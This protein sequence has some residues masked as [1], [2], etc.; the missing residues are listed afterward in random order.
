MWYLRKMERISFRAHKT[1]EF[2]LSK[3]Q[4]SRMILRDIEIRQ[5]KLFG[6]V[7]RKSELEENILFGYINGKR[8]G[9]R[10]RKTSGWYLGKIRKKSSRVHKNRKET[11]RMETFMESLCLWPDTALKEEGSAT[12]DVSE[13]IWKRREPISGLRCESK[14]QS[15]FDLLEPKNQFKNPAVWNFKIWHRI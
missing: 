6:H 7:V 8:S 3:I 12:G 11:R 13:K 4:K 5:L 10:N 9:G 14:I 1:N 2:V 15:H